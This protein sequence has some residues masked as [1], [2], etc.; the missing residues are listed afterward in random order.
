MLLQQQID[1]ILELGPALHA[2]EL[3][4]KILTWDHNL[5]APEYPLEVH[6]SAAGQLWMASPGTSMP[7]ISEPRPM[8]TMHFRPGICA[9]PSN[10]SDAAYGICN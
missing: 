1:F 6:A 7:V 4:T 8:S 10:R 3:D 2:A 9:S 5:D